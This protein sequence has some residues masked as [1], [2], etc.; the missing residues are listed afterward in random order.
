[1]AREA[2]GA[3]L[4]GGAMRSIDATLHRAALI[5]IATSL[6]AT[7]AAGFRWFMAVPPLL[8]FPHLFYAAWNLL[9]VVLMVL[10]ART[11]RS[12]PGEVSTASPRPA[13]DAGPGVGGHP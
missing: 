2:G 10:V 8:G 4:N 5:V 1:L 11:F 12:A 7:W 9:V 3:D 6:A 13:C